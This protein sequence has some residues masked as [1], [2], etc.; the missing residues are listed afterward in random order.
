MMP[1]TNVVVA[2]MRRYARL[3]VSPGTMCI[4]LVQRRLHNVDTD[5]ELDVSS[6]QI[7]QVATSRAAN[8]LNRSIPLVR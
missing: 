7:S 6:G 4:S 5:T 2:N 3:N 8:P 1:D